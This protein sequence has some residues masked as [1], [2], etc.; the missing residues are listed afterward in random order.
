MRFFVAAAVGLSLT[1]CTMSEGV[2]VS[3]A[4]DMIAKQFK[5]PDS[6]QFQNVRLVDPGS[7]P[8]RHWGT[9]CGE[10]NARNGF[11]GYVGFKQFSAHLEYTDDGQLEISA[12]TLDSPSPSC[13]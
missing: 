2:A 5:D 10:V 8:N 12:L 3:A 9:I 11:G 6:A 13:R 4:Q 7:N 1:A